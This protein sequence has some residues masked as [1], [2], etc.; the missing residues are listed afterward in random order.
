MRAG[1]APFL[2][3]AGGER[4]GA[5]RRLRRCPTFT[6]PNNLSIVTGVPPAVHGICGNYFY[7]RD[8][9]AEVMMNDPKYLRCGTILA[10]FADAGAKVAVVTAKDKL[11]TLL[12]HKLKG[13]CFSAEKADDRGERHRVLGCGMPLPSVYS[14]ELSEF[15]F[16][17]GVKLMERDRPD[18]MYLSTTDY[19]QH[20]HAPGTPAANAFYAMM[21]RY[22]ARL[23][24]LGCTIA[25]TADHGMNA[26]T[27]PTARP[28]SSTCRTCSTAGSAPAR[29][30]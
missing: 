18:L 29:R 30:A 21:D 14:A 19:V 10:A 26:K 13:I 5:R 12:G 1:V 9:G 20:K 23:D 7:D 3:R 25:L 2:A 4:H 6:N 8:A 11:R 24:A 16:A 22:L 17:A 28:T 27:A 15:V